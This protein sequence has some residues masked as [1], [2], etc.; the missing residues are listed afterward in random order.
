MANIIRGITKSIV[1]GLERCKAKA[2]AAPEAAGWPEAA[3]VA[4]AKTPAS[5]KGSAEP[6]THVAMV[7]GFHKNIVDMFVASLE[8]KPTRR[9]SWCR[10][11]EL[12]TSA[13]AL[14]NTAGSSAA[15]VK[16]VRN[17]RI[18]GLDPAM[19]KDEFAACKKAASA[20]ESTAVMG[21]AN[22]ILDRNTEVMPTA[23]RTR[24]SAIACTVSLDI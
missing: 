9:A 21:D 8:G 24:R 7:K 1:W 4:A 23:A 14:R 6:E 16:R 22:S 12:I 18:L 15:L 5:F 10:Q 3:A 13:I 17:I 19:S 20:I 11:D 2:K